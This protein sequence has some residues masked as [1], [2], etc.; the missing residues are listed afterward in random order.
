MKEIMDRMVTLKDETE[1]KEQKLQ[2]I[3]ENLLGQ[4][5]ASFTKKANILRSHFEEL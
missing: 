1:M 5:R 4:V 2:A 3:F